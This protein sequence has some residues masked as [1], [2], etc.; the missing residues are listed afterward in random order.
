MA[1]SINQLLTLSV[2][3]LSFVG[4]DIPGFNGKPSEEVYTLFYQLGVFY[5]FM[6]AH[7]HIEAYRREP[8]RQLK[9]V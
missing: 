1:I 8:F 5:P 9:V 2:S 7:G 4:A 6:R 3:G